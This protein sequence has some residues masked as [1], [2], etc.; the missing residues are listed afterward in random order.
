MYLFM[1]IILF[2]A[3][4]DFN[5]RDCIN[6]FIIIIIIKEYL[7]ISLYYIF[8]LHFILASQLL[9][10]LSPVRK[11]LTLFCSFFVS[12]YWNYIRHSGIVE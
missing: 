8:Y 1:V 3:A 6:L 10:L 2:N 11:N 7:Y 5:L 12:A 4:D 9:F